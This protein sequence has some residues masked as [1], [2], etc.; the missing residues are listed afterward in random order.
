MCCK[1]E[2]KY[3]VYFWQ[4]YVFKKLPCVDQLYKKTHEK[5]SKKNARSEFFSLLG[6]K[7]LQSRIGH[8]SLGGNHHLE[9]LRHRIAQTPQVLGLELLGPQLPDGGG[10]LGDGGDVLLLQ[11]VFQMIPTVLD[12]I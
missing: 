2:K 8:V 9:P 6:K 1:Q 10:E 5:T 3:L 12:L 11:E 7:Q 4:V